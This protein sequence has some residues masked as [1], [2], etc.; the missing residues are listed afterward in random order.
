MGITDDKDPTLVHWVVNAPWAHPFWHSYSIVVVHLRPVEGVP[1]PK[2]FL[3]GA[4]HEFWVYALNPEIDN[5]TLIETGIIAPYQWLSP[6][7]FAAQMIETDESAMARISAVVE[8][9][10]NGDLSPDT[11]FRFEWVGRF[12][13]AMVKKELH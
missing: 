9:I 12:G 4:T 1:E 2:I 5:R 3:P 13:G 6:M 10:V 11:D 8:E 7:N